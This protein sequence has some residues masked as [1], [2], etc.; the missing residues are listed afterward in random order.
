MYYE[1]A[2][3]EAINAQILADT[4]EASIFVNITESGVEN[5][6]AHDSSPIEARQVSSQ[7][8]PFHHHA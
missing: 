6:A 7:L 2:D 4:P 3:I 8:P 1:G 5:R